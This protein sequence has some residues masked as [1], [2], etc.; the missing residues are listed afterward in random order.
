MA[1]CDDAPEIR[2]V[3]ENYNDVKD[4]SIH[5]CSTKSNQAFLF[6]SGGF[7]IG[8]FWRLI[9]SMIPTYVEKQLYGSV[10]LISR[11]LVIVPFSSVIFSILF[12]YWTA[13]Q[14]H[15]KSPKSTGILMISSG[16]I[17]VISSILLSLMCYF[18]LIKPDTN[19]IWAFV[20]VFLFFTIMILSM[21]G[22][23]ASFFSISTH[24]SDQL[25]SKS[26]FPF[27]N[28]VGQLLAISLIIII[29]KFFE[30]QSRTLIV[31]SFS[32]FIVLVYLG[33]FW[34]WMM[35]AIFP[36]SNNPKNVDEK[37]PPLQSKLSKTYVC[38]QFGNFFGSGTFF[39]MLFS[40]FL[41]YASLFYF[42]FRMDYVSK[43]SVFF[44]EENQIFV[45]ETLNF[46][47]RLRVY[48]LIVQMSASILFFLIE[49]AMIKRRPPCNPIHVSYGSGTFRLPENSSLRLE[50]H[51]DKRME[52]IFNAQLTTSILGWSVFS[53]IFWILIGL[54]MTTTDVN[55]R[56]F[57]FVITGL[58]ISLIY[59]GREFQRSSMR[60]MRYLNYTPNE[61]SIQHYDF[62]DNMIGSG[63]YSAFMALAQSPVILGEIFHFSL[64]SVYSVIMTA[65]CSLTVVIFLIF[66]MMCVPMCHEEALSHRK[67]FMPPHDQEKDTKLVSSKLIRFHPKF[68]F[69]T[70]NKDA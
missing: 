56:I 8:L 27:W 6:Y 24:F 41:S 15:S 67:P 65:S 14:Q 18:D 68:T 45:D 58:P 29:S 51:S 61:I 57:M 13:I 50:F 54:Q 4:D 28:G 37:V 60:L 19:P 38:K 43:E 25:I 11:L 49:F 44:I 70:L 32:G 1:T 30:S 53:M 52:N 59:S 16:V 34:K 66:G 7:V 69:R 48:Q 46:S 47:L 5:L 31:V 21:N 62:F 2:V 3:D 9:W 33:F 12:G 17:L 64:P 35:C 36:T 20:L 55:L 42:D 26:A 39:Y 23:M 10:N 40:C 63:F 22:Y